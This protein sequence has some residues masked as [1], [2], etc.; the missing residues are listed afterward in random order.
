MATTNNTLKARKKLKGITKKLGL[1]QTC[2]KGQI[3]R[4]PYGRQF[5]NNVKQSGFN[6]HRGNKTVRVY[7]KASSAIVKASCV[8]NR[9]YTPGKN[10]KAIIGPLKKG[11]LTKY[12]YNAHLNRDKRHIALKKAIAAY[13]ALDVYRKLD[14][15]TKLTL[16]TAPDAHKVFETDRKW[17]QSNYTLKK[18]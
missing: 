6:V 9:S 10:D 12:G 5:T 18:V 4:A 17:V 11:E 3:L 16:R 14:A 7:P 2:P 13:G 8:K 15:I 1:N